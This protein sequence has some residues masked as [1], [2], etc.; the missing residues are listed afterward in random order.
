MGKGVRGRLGDW[1]EG[2]ERQRMRI[3]EP[4]Q[5]VVDYYSTH[6]RLVDANQRPRQRKT[7]LGPFP[8]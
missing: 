1:N 8:A 5:G 7:P 3:R 2:C 4:D 6:P